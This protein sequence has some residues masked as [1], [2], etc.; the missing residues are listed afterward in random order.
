V[1]N[2]TE[3]DLCVCRFLVGESFR[4]GEVDRKRRGEREARVRQAGISVSW[5]QSYSVI[6]SAVQ[7]C[8]LR[9][10]GLWQS[11][12]SLSWCCRGKWRRRCPQSSS[13]KY[14]DALGVGCSAGVRR[15]VAIL[16]LLG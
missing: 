3:Q 6:E 16:V 9:R 12:G 13:Y 1:T 15:P 7:C 10:S 14:D 11:S 4:G 8:V 2:W 5:P